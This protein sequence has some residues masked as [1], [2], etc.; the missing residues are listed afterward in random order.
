MMINIH[1]VLNN[2]AVDG[3]WGQWS[4]WG[5]CNVVCGQGDKRRTR[6]CNNPPPGKRVKREITLNY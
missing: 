2:C 4:H 6:N 5:Y 3:N 1:S